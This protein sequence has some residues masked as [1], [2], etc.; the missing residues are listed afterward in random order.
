MAEAASG[1]AWD[2]GQYL[3]FTGE[4]LRPAVDLLARVPLDAPRYVVDLGC[5]PGNVTAILRQRFPAAVLIG[6]DGSPA[7]L[8]RARVTVPGCRFELADFHAWRPSAPVDLIYSNAALQWVDRHAELLPRLLSFLAPGGAL[9]IQMPMMRETPLHR[10]AR[11][12]AASAEWAEDMQG[13]VPQPAILA[14]AGYWDLLRP[15][16]ASLDM[17]QTTYM[18]ALQG[19]N[20]VLEWATGSG[21]RPYLDPLTEARKAAFRAAYAEGTRAHYPRRGDGSTLLPF[22]RLFMVACLD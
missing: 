3:R 4:R 7:M 11:E 21:L 17:W 13:V 12:L 20:A 19:E 8:D 1:P 18:H 6:V 9:A 16:V 15:R 22:H 5:G 14:P 10:V 2:P